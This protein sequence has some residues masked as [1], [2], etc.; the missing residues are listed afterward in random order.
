MLDLF[1]YVYIYVYMHPGA[2]EL[3]GGGW[4]RLREPVAICLFVLVWL[5]CFIGSSAYVCVLCCL[6]IFVSLIA[7]AGTFFVTFACA[8]FVYLCY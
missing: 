6:Y 5:I 7:A 8:Y 4:Q 1:E 2:G 3:R